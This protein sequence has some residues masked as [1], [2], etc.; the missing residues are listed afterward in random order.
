MIFDMGGYSYTYTQQFIFWYLP[1]SNS[2]MDTRMF[3]TALF[4]SKNVEIT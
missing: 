2:F 4:A 1:S 3:T